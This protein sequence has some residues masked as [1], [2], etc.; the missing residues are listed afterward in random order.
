MEDAKQEVDLDILEKASLFQY[1]NCAKT[2]EGRK[3]LA[4]LL[5]WKQQDSEQI[6]QR[7]EAVKECI[8]STDLSLRFMQLSKLLNGMQGKRKNVRW[9]IFI[10]QWKLM[11]IF[12][13]N[14]GKEY[15]YLFLYVV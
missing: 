8:S 10:R 1:L 15:A 14:Y 2:M 6:K 9:S 3:Y 4:S 5:S 13:R 7:Q 12:M 11:N